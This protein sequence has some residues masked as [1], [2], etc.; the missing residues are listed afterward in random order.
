[1]DVLAHEMSS[2]DRV[3][4]TVHGH[5]LWKNAIERAFGL[6][7]S[8]STNYVVLTREATFLSWASVCSSVKG[9]E[10]SGENSACFHIMFPQNIPPS[11]T[12]SWNRIHANQFA[13]PPPPTSNKQ[14]AWHITLNLTS[15]FH[16]HCCFKSSVQPHQVGNSQ[17]LECK[18]GEDSD[19]LMPWS[20]LYSQVREW[21]EL[22]VTRETRIELFWP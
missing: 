20:W 15:F 21:S 5:P 10:S 2:R 19:S 17:G 13:S 12:S 11:S 6:S 8:F 22:L 9:S 14:L 4:Q 7:S 16:F 1:M 3:S 18:A